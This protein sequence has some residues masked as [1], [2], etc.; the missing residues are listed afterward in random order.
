MP[1]ADP[2]EAKRQRRRY[3]LENRDHILERS[4]EYARNNRR[5]TLE[6]LFNREYGITLD[7]YELILLEQGNACAIC[8]SRVADQRGHRLHV[9]HNHKTGLVRG[10]L[11]GKCNRALGY[12][13]DSLERLYLAV[14]Y[15]ETA[16]E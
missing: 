6:N 8:N 2:A 12:F 11:C 3:Y 5:R 1:Y 9:D 7:D 14:A 10:L 13:D 16:N 15:M 4:K